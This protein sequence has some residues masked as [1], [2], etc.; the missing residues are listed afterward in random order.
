MS[1]LRTYIDQAAAW[2][3]SIRNRDGGWGIYEDSATFV[4]STAEAILGLEQAGVP[5]VE[6]QSSLEYLQ[7]SVLGKHELKAQYLRHF[8]WAGD[9]LIRLGEPGDSPAVKKCFDWLCDNQNSVGGWSHSPGVLSNTYA[10]YVAT[11]PFLEALRRNLK[12]FDRRYVR[13]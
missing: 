4:L 3:M 2:L 6:Y 1:T 9:A 5:K 11:R 13:K 12:G 7:D 8:A 10:S